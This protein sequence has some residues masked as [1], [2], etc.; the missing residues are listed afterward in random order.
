MELEIADRQKAVECP[1]EAIRR[2]LAAALR[3]AGRDAELSVA[4]IGDDEAAE[5]N[6]RFL[7]REGVT[8][9]LAFPYDVEGDMLKGEIVANAEL[10]AREAEGRSHG[11][12]DE[13]LL[14]VVHGLLHLLGYDDQ[15]PEDR[16]RMRQRESEVLAEVGRAVEF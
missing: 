8:D 2:A 3:V 1:R 6:R 12:A 10:A 15:T 14:Y 4:L 13:L 5:L 9:V 11:A 16:R 7:G